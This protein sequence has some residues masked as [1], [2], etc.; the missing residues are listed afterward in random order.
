MASPA[1]SN[2]PNNGKPPRSKGMKFTWYG[3]TVVFLLVWVPLAAIGSANNFLF[4]VFIMT[5]GLAFVSHSLGRA[6]VSSVAVFR[7]FPREIFADTLFAV[8]YHAQTR[9]KRWGALTFTFRE[10]APL[11]SV[12]DPI[13]FPRLDPGHPSEAV[14]YFTLPS[15]GDHVIR[16]GIVSSSFPFNL[17]IYSRNCGEM[18]SVLVY[19]KIRPI[20]E[21][22]PIQVGG[23]SRGPERIDP[24]GTMPY[25]FRDYAVG[26]PYKFID[27][28]KTARSGA[29]VTRVHSEEGMDR[30]AIRLPADASE[31]ALSRAASLVVHCSRTNIPLALEG[32]GVFVEPG[33]GP[34]FTRKLLTLLAR[35]QNT[36]HSVS[37]NHDF[38]GMVVQVEQDGQFTWTPTGERHE[39]SSSGTDGH[40]RDFTE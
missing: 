30:I 16:P 1:S 21:P 13:S 11:Q 35:W 40:D 28:K 4:I 26:D 6:N 38:R 9:R 17:T 31:E 34:Q 12:D 22:L 5:A 24:F 25:Y 14:G 27:W 37:G 2:T 8:H 10:S 15:R 33:T 36:T 7:Q 20:T 32:P 29:L 3:W 23:S 39:W 19:P 18:E